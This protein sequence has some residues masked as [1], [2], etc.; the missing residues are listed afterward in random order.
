MDIESHFPAAS[1]I[2]LQFSRPSFLPPSRSSPF[3]TTAHQTTDFP[4]QIII[5]IKLTASPYPD[6]KWTSE[7][8]TVGHPIFTSSN[9]LPFPHHPCPRVPRVTQEYQCLLQVYQQRRSKKPPIAH[10]YSESW[11]DSV[12]IY[13]MASTA[14]KYHPQGGRRRRLGS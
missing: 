7:P 1:F 13:H 3:S 9:P 2:S 4:N 6:T 14:P 11:P 8:S 5:I 10:M 12:Y